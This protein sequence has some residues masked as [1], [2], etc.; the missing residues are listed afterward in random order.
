MYV[1]SLHGN[2]PPAMALDPETPDPGALAITAKKTFGNPK[3]LEVWICLQESFYNRI[4][5]P[6]FFLESEVTNILF[7]KM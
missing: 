4:T 2:S 5:V 1:R 7:L 6:I 3:P